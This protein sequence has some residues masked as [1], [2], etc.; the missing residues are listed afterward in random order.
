MTI[1]TDILPDLVPISSRDQIVILLGIVGLAF[2][3]TNVLR[4]AACA[5]VADLRA[6]YRRRERVAFRRHTM[7]R[8]RSTAA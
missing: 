2:I 6:I 3:A 8:R 7:S 5:A 4:Y 1:R